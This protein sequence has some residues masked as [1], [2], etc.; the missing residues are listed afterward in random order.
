MQAVSILKNSKKQGTTIF[1]SYNHGTAYD[2]S[3]LA[4]LQYPGLTDIH[5]IQKYF[6]FN[7]K[8]NL[9]IGVNATYEN[10]IGGDIK[11]IEGNG[12][13]V[14]SYFEKN[15]T[16]RYSTQFSVDHKLNDKQHSTS[17]T[18]LAITIGQFKFQITYFQVC[19][20]QATVS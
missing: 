1:A 4:L 9:N 12:D 18:V 19:N 11:Y 5:S 13:N 17:K 7:K 16:N 6:Y 20:F 8:H 15:S 10:R 2:P 3:I 14:H